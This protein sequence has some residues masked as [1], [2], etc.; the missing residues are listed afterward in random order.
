MI[1]SIDAWTAEVARSSTTA[2]PPQVQAIADRLAKEAGRLVG[3]AG[4]V[5]P[6]LPPEQWPIL[7]M[8]LADGGAEVRTRLGALLVS[9]ESYPSLGVFAIRVPP[10]P[11]F[12]DALAREPGVRAISSPRSPMKAPRPLAGDPYRIP[13]VRSLLGVPDDRGPLGQGI[14]VAIL[15]GGIDPDHPDFSK[16]RF[17]H[18]RAF[19]DEPDIIDR[20][21]HGSHTAGILAGS[22]RASEGRFAGVAP[23]ATLMV[24]KIFDRTGPAPTDRI[25]RGLTWAL[26]LRPHVISLSF[27]SPGL[28]GG[29][30]LLSL[31]VERVAQAGIMVVA[32]SGNSGP[33]E[34][35]IAS[36]ADAPSVI[37]VGAVDASLELAYFSS[38][39][40]PGARPAAAKP[41]VVAPGVSVCAPRSRYATSLP[42]P[43]A[44]YAVMSG[45]SMACPAVAGSLA[46][47][48]SRLPPRRREASTV[49]LPA[50]LMA[51]SRR[52]R[53]P[54]GVY[55]RPFEAGHG[56]P[57]VRAA[58]TSAAA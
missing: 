27:G 5:R 4:A 43:P 21:G 54:L 12:I 2:N 9:E 53:S 58:A 46:V 23:E 45:T 36:P 1:A 8:A 31:A 51:T 11:N 52:L 41:N 39:G 38:R 19:G 10:G 17:K 40:D 37:A 26:E 6:Y 18:L 30:S 50:R 28:P 25:L 47:L 35:T 16:Q 57:S 55:Y 15:D 32:A 14:D 42:G 13:Q 29:R 48:L 33:A 20:D 34:N 7:L 49:S 22:G 3:A 44:D 56:L 24:G